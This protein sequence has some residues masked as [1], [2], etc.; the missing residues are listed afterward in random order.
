[1]HVIAIH[2]LF[3][4]KQQ[5]TS[6]LFVTSVPVTDLEPVTFS[7]ETSGITLGNDAAPF[8]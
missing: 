7:A 5:Q 1:M 2:T 3:K 4:K 8:P 6:L